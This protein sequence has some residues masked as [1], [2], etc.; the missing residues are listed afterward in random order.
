MV[1]RRGGKKGD[2]PGPRRRPR[3]APR[4]AADDAPPRVGD[5]EL[6]EATIR[7]DIPPTLGWGTFFQSHLELTVVATNRYPVSPTEIVAELRFEVGGDRDWSSELRHVPSIVSVSRLDRTGRPEVYRMRWKAPPFYVQLLKQFDFV[8]MVPFRIAAGRATLSIAL[9][10]SRLREL[11]RT[12]HGRGFA[13]DLRDVRPFRG[14]SESGGLTPKQ[15]DRFRAAVESGYFDVP[16]RVTL[17]ELSARFSVRKSAFAES[18][19]LARRKVLI[20][21]GRLLSAEAMAPPR[22][23][24]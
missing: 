7:T 13:P 8:G 3:G 4:S 1:P 16:R 17:D 18:L 5:E 21:A 24:P 11:M 15:R 12:L 22:P 20:S 10:R 6:V 14:R 9:T 19:A 2:V 23:P